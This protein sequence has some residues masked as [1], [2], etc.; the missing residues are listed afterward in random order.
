MQRETRTQ[1]CYWTLRSRDKRSPKR[2][3]GSITAIAQ[4]ELLTRHGVTCSRM[5]F[6]RQPKSLVAIGV[7]NARELRKDDVR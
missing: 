7:A 5:G 6:A 1:V 4:R 3:F 2:C